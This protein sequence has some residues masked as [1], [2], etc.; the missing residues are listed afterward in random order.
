MSQWQQLL[1]LNS[2]LQSRVSQLYER[3]FPREIRHHL[4]TWIE[5]QDWDL[6]ATD[7]TRAIGC[8]QVMLVYLEEE[9]NRS[10]QEKNIL[11]GP[12]FSL[13]KDVLLE[14]FSTQP[15]KLAM[16]LSECLKEEQ[17]I[18]DSASEV[19]SCSNPVIDQSWS[20][21]DSKVSELKQQTTDV[22]K[23]IKMLEGLNEQLNYIQKT[24]QREVEEHV[25]LAQSQSMVEEECLRQAF[26][27]TETKQIVLDQLVNILNQAEQI[28]AALIDVELPSWRRRQQIA[29]I[30]SPVDTCL[31]HLQNWF[32]AVAEVLLGVHDQLQKLQEQNSKYSSHDGLGLPA[33]VVEMEKC[34]LSLLKKVVTNALVVERQPVTQNLPHRP[35][36]IKTNVRFSVTVRFLVNLPQ[37]KCMLKVKPV[38]DKDVEEVMKAKGFRL[39]D[40]NQGDSKV[41]DQDSQD[42]SLITEWNN[43]SLKE[44]K[45]KT[46]G[47]IESRLGVTEELHIIKFVTELR[48]A[49][50]M[51][52]IETSSLPMVVVSSTSQFSA[53]WA[54]IMWWNMLSTSQP[55]NLLLFTNPPPL[56]WEQLAQ[57][58]SWQFLVV[59]QRGLEENQLSVLKEKIVDDPNDLVHWS[60]FSKYESAWTWIDGILDLIKK[61]L[62]DFW[63]DGSIMGFVS[64]ERTKF[65]LENQ[66]TGTFLLRFSET[67]REGAITFSWVNH[68]NGQARVHAV[69]PYTKKE[70]A[71]MTLADIVYRYTLT[72]TRKP[73]NPLIYLY[74]NTHKDVAF[75][76]YYQPS[77]TVK[78]DGY[79]LR[80]PACMSDDP[81]PPPSPPSEI[82]RMDTDL[83]MDTDA[84]DQ[85]K[86]LLSDLLDSPIRKS[87]LDCSNL[88]LSPHHLNTLVFS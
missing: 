43:L 77:E 8:F 87:H 19:Q 53:A 76:R 63:R 38:F 41:L 26:F 1:R 88:L 33:S 73:R 21:L 27:I 62:V 9:W 40:L 17:K 5:S 47:S 42:G 6:A 48:Y 39:F 36:I 49:G 57:V 79:I 2:E 10:M 12:D 86:E 65:L 44:R 51:Y 16:L 23:E 75:G 14:H 34:T 11:E 64:R 46:K 15:L 54:S 31:D 84:D 71:V 13:M 24:W 60:N 30:G 66:Q 22:K 80:R 81:S 74:P 50:Q 37:F 25:G 32:T 4:C 83:N 59:G 52:N 72:N 56:P 29:C 69:Q 78:N 7:E 82:C 68:V 85:R 55:W 35:L 18:L 58:L 20:E 67:C 61:H 70:L 45:S 3:R 28:V